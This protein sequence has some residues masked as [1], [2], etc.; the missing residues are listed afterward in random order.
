MSA[1]SSGRLEEWTIDPYTGERLKVIRETVARNE[2]RI[3]Y[4]VDSDGKRHGTYRRYSGNKL[5]EEIIYKHGL[6]HGPFTSYHP[7]NGSVS[8]STG[9]QTLRGKPWIKGT[10]VDGLRDGLYQQWFPDGT[11][12]HKCFYTRGA[13]DGE[14]MDYYLNGKSMQQRF[15]IN[16]KLVGSV[17]SWTSDGKLIEDYIANQGKN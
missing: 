11:L 15:Y 3:V 17:K 10:Y 8:S 1:P 12:S 16:G 7:S 9:D 13:L 4:H 6:F 2:D 5:Q 14:M